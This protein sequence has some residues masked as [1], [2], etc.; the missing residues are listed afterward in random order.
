MNDD[1]FKALK[2][3][4]KE[5]AKVGFHKTELGKLERGKH[6]EGL[7][8]QGLKALFFFCCIKQP[9]FKWPSRDQNNSNKI[10]NIFKEWFTLEDILTSLLNQNRVIQHQ[11]KCNLGSYRMYYLYKL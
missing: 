6:W 1:L 11:K 7:T 10:R 9:S 2:S 3:A 4:L 8:L 5:S